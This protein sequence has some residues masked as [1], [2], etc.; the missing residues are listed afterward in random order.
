[1][2]GKRAERIMHADNLMVEGNFMGHQE[3]RWAAGDNL[4]RPSP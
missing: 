4:A 1:M 2:A 3:E